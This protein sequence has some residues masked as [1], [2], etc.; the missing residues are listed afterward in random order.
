MEAFKT[1]YQRY[2]LIGTILFHLLLL[3]VFL[4]F[5]LKTPVPIP[6]ESIAINFG[7]SDEGSGE[8]Q[9][10]EISASQV[11]E[12]AQN[13]PEPV[14]SNPMPAVT[15][16]VTQ[17]NSDALPASEKETEQVVETPKE[18]ERQ[19]N[20]KA[21]FPGKKNTQSSNSSE[22][23]TG[24]AGDQG[25]PDGSKEATSHTGGAG[26]GDSYD[27]GSRKA[28]QKIKPKYECQETGKVVVTIHVDRQG[29]VVK[30]TG[31]G[32]GTTNSAACLVTRAQEAAMKT[33]WEADADAPEL[34]IGR[35][36]YNFEL[37]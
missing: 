4:L 16:A 3:L 12:P 25:D 36:V 22:G 29:N 31:G 15:D 14:K 27:L 2:G 30:A 19:V 9:P 33:K 35:I 23:E 5:G 24:K 32:R 21:L 18:P 8:I 37:K 28:L 7:T 1:K 11:N 6:Q 34:Q 13:T 10:E 20:Q 26:G 17:D